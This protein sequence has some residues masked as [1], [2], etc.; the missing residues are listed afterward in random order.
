MGSTG[1]AEAKGLLVQAQQLAAVPQGLLAVRIHCG[2][3]GQGGLLEAHVAQLQQT[4]QH[5]PDGPH[6]LLVELQRVHGLQ[7]VAEVGGVV[8]SGDVDA[9]GLTQV[10]VLLGTLQVQ[11]LE[12][13]QTEWQS[14]WVHAI[15]V[16]P[17]TSTHLPNH[18]PTLSIAI[19][20][21]YAHQILFFWN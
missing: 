19:E 16:E 18:F 11:G 8:H 14:E 15:V 20:P 4:R 17:H 3:V 10:A 1:E 2:R 12:A 7:H 21:P 6:G 5:P 9:A 13:R